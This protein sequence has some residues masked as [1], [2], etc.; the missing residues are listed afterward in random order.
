MEKLM[1]I[2]GLVGGEEV[3]GITNAPIQKL[4][5]S[6]KY[7]PRICMPARVGLFGPSCCGKSFMIK[8]LVKHRE[9]IFSHSIERMIY[10]CNDLSSRATQDYVGELL[11][12]FPDLETFTG[13]PDFDELNITTEGHKLLILDDLADELLASSR[14]CSVMTKDSHHKKV[15]V[16]FTLQNYYH[17]SKKGKTFI[18][19]VSD[20]FFFSAKGEKAMLKQ[21]SQTL[22]QNAKVLVEAMRYVEENLLEEGTRYLLLDVNQL[23][24]VPFNMSV[25]TNIFPDQDGNITPIFFFFQD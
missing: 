23:S 11:E 3:G 15:T 22:L 8:Q 13:L 4:L 5:V 25:R 12:Y 2:P 21:I 1:E 10:S 17:P 16:L 14:Y 20:S 9:I 24:G 7:G 19:Q 18:R 6:D